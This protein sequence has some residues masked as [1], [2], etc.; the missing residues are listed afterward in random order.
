VEIDLASGRTV[1][2]GTPN[3]EDVVKAVESLGFSIAE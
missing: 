2:H 3:K 1:V